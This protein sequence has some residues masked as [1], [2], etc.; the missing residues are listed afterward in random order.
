MIT[1]LSQQQLR[2]FNLPYQLGY[3]K[4]EDGTPDTSRF[5]TPM[6]AN[7]S[8]YAT[9]PGDIVI[10]ATDGLYDNVELNEIVDIT[11][12]WETAWFHG[13]N[14]G[15][16]LPGR[17][18][19]SIEKQAMD[20]L[21]TMLCHRARKLSIDKKIDSPFAQLAKENDIM[22]SGGMPDD[23]TVVALRVVRAEEK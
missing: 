2:S 8:A 15:R 14:R 1:F 12:R 18:R 7:V 19:E 21:A 10:V 17:D 6:D 11:R 3:S 23:G 20:N 4:R 22:W 5:E 9:R 16:N 13:P